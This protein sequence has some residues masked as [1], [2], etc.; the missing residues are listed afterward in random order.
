MLWSIVEDG[1][2]MW[3]VTVWYMSSTVTPGHLADWHRKLRAAAAHERPPTTLDDDAAVY[4]PLADVPGLGR[5]EGVYVL[6]RGYEWSVRSVREWADH[7]ACMW[8]DLLE[9][10]RQM[11]ADMPA[12]AVCVAVDAQ[13][14]RGQLAR[15]L[16]YVLL[17]SSGVDDV[18]SLETWLCDKKASIENC[19]DDSISDWTCC[20]NASNADTSA[21]DNV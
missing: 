15:Y 2:G 13:V 14:P 19:G 21:A 16:S 8:D 9:C 10:V 12:H 5:A 7:D 1:P 20:A 4:A 3:A 18:S 17:P 6:P 11:P